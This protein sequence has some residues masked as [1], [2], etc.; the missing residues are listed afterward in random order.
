[1]LCFAKD[2][3]AL[4]NVACESKTTMLVSV[5]V[6][7]SVYRSIVC[8][9]CV[10]ETIIA[11]DTC[12]LWLYV[13]VA[14]SQMKRICRVSFLDLYVCVCV[15]WFN[16][17]EQ[18]TSDTFEPVCWWRVCVYVFSCLLSLC[19]AWVCKAHAFLLV[20]GYLKWVWI[21]CIKDDT[22]AD[23]SFCLFIFTWYRL[24]FFLLIC[25]FNRYLH[26]DK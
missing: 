11:L 15:L 23:I 14:V 18:S 1:M 22:W 3:K 26:W 9:V 4:A 24:F 12:W 13:L 8:F 7:G 17:W 16:A 19:F 6:Y 20:C 2:C 21:E 5:F 10:R 25:N